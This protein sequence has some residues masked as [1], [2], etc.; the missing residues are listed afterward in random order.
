MLPEHLD[1]W[2][3]PDSYREASQFATWD[4]RGI[5]LGKGQAKS[6]SRLQPR[7]F[8]LSPA[9]DFSGRGRA[10]PKTLGPTVEKRLPH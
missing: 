1:R 4:A 6:R 9:S 8:S 5:V 10:G 3:R 7:S 2:T